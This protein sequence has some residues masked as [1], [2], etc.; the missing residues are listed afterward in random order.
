MILLCLLS[1]SA[2]GKLT[3]AD[4]D[5]KINLHGS[6]ITSTC[7]SSDN[8][9]VT[10]LSPSSVSMGDIISGVSVRARFYGVAHTCIDAPLRAPCVSEDP[11]Y[12]KLFYTEWAAEGTS[13]PLVKGPFAA[14]YTLETTSDGIKLGYRTWLDCPLPTNVE[15]LELFGVTVVEHGSTLVLRIRHFA[16]EG[17]DSLLLPFRG[18]PGGNTIHLLAAPPAPPPAAPLGPCQTSSSAMVTLDG[19]STY[20]EVLGDEQYVKLMGLGSA[21]SYTMGTSSAI[22]AMAAPGANSNVQKLSDVDINRLRALAAKD[23]RGRQIYRFKSTGTDDYGWFAQK[24]DAVW[25]DS[26]KNWGVFG[27]R[28]ACSMRAS[29][30][31]SYSTMLATDGWFETNGACGVSGGSAAWCGS[32]TDGFAFDHIDF[33]GQVGQAASRYFIGHSS[34]DCHKDASKRCFCGGSTFTSNGQDHGILP[35]VEVFMFLGLMGSSAIPRGPCSLALSAIVTLDGVST[36]CEVLGDEQYVK[37]MGLGSAGSYTM[38]TSSAIGAMAAPGANSNVQKLSDVDINRLRALAAKDGRGRQ[39][40]RFKSTGTDDYGWFAQKADAV[41]ID[42]SKNWGVFGERSACSM[43]AST[44]ASYSTMLA[45]DGWFETNG[46]CGVSGG[47]AA[48]CGSCT[49]GFAFDHIDFI[50]QVGQAASRYFIGHSSG[51]C[52]KDASKRCFCGGSTFTSNGQ[53]H[54]ILPNVEVFMYM[55][56][57]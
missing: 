1:L 18:L 55:G 51:D 10:F 52:H 19:V 41:W 28:S 50:G 49:D 35:N 29:T 2:G 23:G 16:A 25:I 31:A 47:S 8:A 44:A 56:K 38:G 12:P 22:G 48:W 46:A 13:T 54:G 43:R 57:S 40:Y 36:Y 24:A 32:C 17:V 3:I 45:T 5:A 30:A 37:L 15:L 20:C 14:S 34:G 33:I 11:E 9:Q 39:I 21:G 42:S 27:E 7:A 6:A 26:S 53:N 4:A